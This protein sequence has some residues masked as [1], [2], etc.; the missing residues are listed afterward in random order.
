MRIT[1]A[2]NKDC[3]LDRFLALLYK[4]VKLEG[5]ALDEEFRGGLLQPAA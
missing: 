3:G 2:D 5:N 4:A 1:L